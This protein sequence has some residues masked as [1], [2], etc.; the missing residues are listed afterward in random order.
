MTFSFFLI[1]GFIFPG[2]MEKNFFSSSSNKIDKIYMNLQCLFL[3]SFVGRNG[4]SFDIGP[5][6]VVT[7]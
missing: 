2:L 4:V 3:K 5:L 6:V 1:H 7:V